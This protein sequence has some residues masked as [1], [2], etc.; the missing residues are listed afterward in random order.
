[1]AGSFNGT[2]VRGEMTGGALL[3]LSLPVDPTAK[4]ESTLAATA[5]DG[6]VAAG[7]CVG[8]EGAFFDKEG[9]CNKRFLICFPAKMTGLFSFVAL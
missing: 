3:F 6:G 2:F 5:F 8:G 4:I 1:M 9:G 7:F